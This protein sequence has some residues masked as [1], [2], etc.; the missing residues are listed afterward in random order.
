MVVKGDPEYVRNACEGSLERLGVDYI[1]L[2]YQHRVDTKVPIEVTVLAQI[3]LLSS[4]YR[5]YLHLETHVVA[6][7]PGW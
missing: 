1:D 6:W 7:F 3:Y 2:Y 5:H 4:L